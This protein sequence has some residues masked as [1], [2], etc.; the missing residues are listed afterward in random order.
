MVNSLLLK[1]AS[2]L[3]N[4]WCELPRMDSFIVEPANTWSNISFLIV[5]FIIYR[6]SSST[7]LF[8]SM[9]VFAFLFLG[10]GS[11]IF[12]ASMSYFGQILDIAGMYLL[13]TFFLFGLLR[14]DLRQNKYVFIVFYFILNLFIIGL[15]YFFPEFR[16]YI[17]ASLIALLTACSGF[18]IMRFKQKKDF[19]YS[20]LFFSLGVI[21]WIL[22]RYKIICSPESLINLHCF[23]HFLVAMGGYKYY[24]FLKRG[25]SNEISSYND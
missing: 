19:F 18:E 9:A 3:P 15:A 7:S 23:W 1:K 25:R 8:D 4:C 2:C 22:D 20:L 13:C 12:H 10:L 6:R 11:I 5:A 17:F 24:I 21:A 14:L 16:R